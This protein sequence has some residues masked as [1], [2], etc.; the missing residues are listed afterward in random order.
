MPVMSF[1]W[2]VLPH[3]PSYCTLATNLGSPNYHYPRPITRAA[4]SGCE[5]KLAVLPQKHFG[6][7]L[8]VP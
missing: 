3:L 1:A 4:K 5:A 8:K 7:V 6:P 2:V